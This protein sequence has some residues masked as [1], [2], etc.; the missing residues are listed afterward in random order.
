[1]KRRTQMV[2]GHKVITNQSIPVSPNR[3]RQERKPPY[4]RERD[5]DLY[6][7]KEK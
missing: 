1:M 2:Q 7:R 3:S 5:E 6:E 4:A